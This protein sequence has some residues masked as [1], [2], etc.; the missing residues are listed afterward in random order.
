MKICT[1]CGKEIHSYCEKYFYRVT[2]KVAMDSWR[3]RLKFWIIPF[4]KFKPEVERFH[5]GCKS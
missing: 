1:K 4:W 3:N 5:E 2:Y